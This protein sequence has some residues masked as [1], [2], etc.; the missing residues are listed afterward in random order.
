[1]PYSTYST[2]ICWR[3]AVGDLGWGGN[4]LGQVIWL[5]R[6]LCW[7]ESLP[8]PHCHLSPPRSQLQSQHHF[9]VNL[10]HFSLY[11][12]CFS[13][14]RLSSTPSQ[15]TENWRE[16]CVGWE[17]TLLMALSNSFIPRVG[18]RQNSRWS[19]ELLTSCS[20]LPPSGGKLVKFRERVPYPVPRGG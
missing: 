19:P 5:E 4:R 20:G 17:E 13:A 8:F 3:G 15:A 16:G 2:G 9:V 14:T 1:M 11:S 12:P 7:A 10:L 6:N 18:Q